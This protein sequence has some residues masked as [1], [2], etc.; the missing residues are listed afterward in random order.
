MWSV[1]GAFLTLASTVFGYYI[2]GSKSKDELEL[3]SKQFALSKAQL[4]KAADSRQSILE[5]KLRILEL[6]NKIKGDKENG[7]KES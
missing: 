4:N 6:K 5:Q 2:T 7:S 1:I 3:A